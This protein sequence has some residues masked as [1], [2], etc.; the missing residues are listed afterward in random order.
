[1]FYSTGQVGKFGLWELELEAESWIGKERER[2]LGW[3]RGAHCH[4]FCL[5]YIR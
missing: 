3:D 4:S 2:E 1:M 5:R